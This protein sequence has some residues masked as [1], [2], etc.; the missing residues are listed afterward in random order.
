MSPPP[1][2]YVYG[3]GSE[4]EYMR[5]V[6]QG[7]RYQEDTRITFQKA[8]IGHGMR[9]LDVGCGVGEVTR[10]VVD[11]VGP[12][13][14]AVGI[15]MNPGALAFARRHVPAA[16]VEFRR[17]AVDDFHDPTAFDSV[18]GRFILMHL[19]GPVAALRK[20]ASYVPSSGVVCF[21]EPWHGISLSYPASKNST[22]LWKPRS[23]RCEP[24][25]LISRWAPDCIG[26][27]RS[28]SSSSATVHASRDGCGR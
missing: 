15:D 19:K 5:L 8:G 9:V 17:S 14:S 16:N 22:P 7:N 23:T 12:T 28:R 18:V 6:R 11:L 24:P 20:L 4:F 27:H 13:G 21:I 1:K 25:A 10:I 26:L 3:H 2:Q